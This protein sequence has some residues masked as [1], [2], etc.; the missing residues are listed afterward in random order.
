[1]RLDDAVMQI[2]ARATER[3]FCRGLIEALTGGN[4]CLRI[5]GAEKGDCGVRS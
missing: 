2:A 5:G 3:D 4:G 1:M